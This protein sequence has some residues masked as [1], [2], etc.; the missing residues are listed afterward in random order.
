MFFTIHTR[1]SIERR[2]NSVMEVSE[3]QNPP[4]NVP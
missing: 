4:L 3:L 1:N 2:D